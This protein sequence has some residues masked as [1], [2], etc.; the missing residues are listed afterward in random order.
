MPAHTIDT[1]KA[2]RKNFTMPEETVRELEFLAA[3]MNK[4]QSQVI[5]E[6]IHKASEKHLKE[7][8][9]ASLKRLSGIFDDVLP[10]DELKSIQQIKSESTL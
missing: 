10:V 3:A 4:K 7:E 9:L 8:R 6:L 2:K 5:Q 1:P